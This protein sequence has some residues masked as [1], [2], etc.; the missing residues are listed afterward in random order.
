MSYWIKDSQK[1]TCVWFDTASNTFYVSSLLDYLL[2][3]LCNVSPDSSAGT[4]RKD[5]SYTLLRGM[6]T[7]PKGNLWREHICLSL[8]GLATLKGVGGWVMRP[9]VGSSESLALATIVFS[10]KLAGFCPLPRISHFSCLSF[11]MGDGLTWLKYC[12]L[13]R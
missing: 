10:R 12:W 4:D 13:S 7:I 11:S 3:P 9:S 6:D 5:I 1:D 8:H 2:F